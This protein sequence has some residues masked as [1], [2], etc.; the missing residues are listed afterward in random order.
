MFLASKPASLVTNIVSVIWKKFQWSHCGIESFCFQH[1]PH[2]N[3]SVVG[4]KISMIIGLQYGESLLF[5]SKKFIQL[6]ACRWFY[7]LWLIF[8][9]V[10]TDIDIIDDGLRLRCHC[11][12]SKIG[13]FMIF[14]SAGHG[15]Q[16][17]VTWSLSHLDTREVRRSV[18]EPKRTQDRPSLIR[19]DQIMSELSANEPPWMECVSHVCPSILCF[20]YGPP[21]RRP[22]VKAAHAPKCPSLISCQSNNRHKQNG[23]RT[24]FFLV[25][26]S[27]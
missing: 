5:S 8:W 4:Y 19:T 14:W 20:S 12:I 7:L 15:D 18:L 2:W 23:W 10:C 16:M 1:A 26:A 22:T 6:K 3:V 9:N 25:R 11:H 24:R 27:R 17:L 13:F 21:K